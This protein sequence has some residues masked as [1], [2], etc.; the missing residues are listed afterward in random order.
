M[1]KRLFNRTNLN[2]ESLEERVVPTTDFNAI[3]SN[4]GDN[5]GQD[6]GAIYYDFLDGEV[7]EDNDSPSWIDILSYDYGDARGGTSSSDN[8]SNSSD[9]TLTDLVFIQ[10]QEST[11]PILMYEAVGKDSS[12]IQLIQRR[13]HNSQ[14]YLTITINEP[15]IT[16]Y[17][18]SDDSDIE[19]AINFNFSQVTFQY[20][21]ENQLP[22]GAPV[23]FAA[24]NPP[25]GN[26]QGGQGNNQGGQNN[27]NGSP[28]NVS[29]TLPPEVENNLTPDQKQEFQDAVDDYDEAKENLKEA[30]DAAQQAAHKFAQDCDNLDELEQKAKDA[31]DAA[32]QAKK[33][34]EDA[35][36]KVDDLKSDLDKA[37]RKRDIYAKQVNNLATSNIWDRWASRYGVNSHPYRQLQRVFQQQVDLLNQANQKVKDLENQLKEAEADAEE[38]KDKADQKAQEADQAQKEY[39]NAKEH[40]KKCKQMRDNAFAAL[41]QAVKD[42]EKAEQNLAA[43]GAKAAQQAKDNQQ[44][45]LENDLQEK[46]DALDKAQQDLNNKKQQLEKAKEDAAHRAHILDKALQVLDIIGQLSDNVTEE[47]RSLIVQWLGEMSVVAGG[48]VAPPGFGEAIG[49]LQGLYNL[50]AIRQSQLT[51]WHAAYIGDEEMI[52]WLIKKG[53]ANNEKE[54]QEI[55]DAMW[56]LKNNPVQV[57]EEEKNMTQEKIQ[58]CEEEIQRLEQ[59]VERLQQ[60]VDQAQQALNDFQNN[61]RNQ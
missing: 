21:P 51:P 45:Q 37:K 23:N 40:C 32:D 5:S 17:S 46:Q 18:A 10:M 53:H 60:Q 59:E 52:K 16:S 2:L 47:E 38:A 35:Q 13:D 24:A 6:T 54:A 31:Q 50:I 22:Q 20:K 43:A 26:N 36:D 7:K 28:N 58:K 44:Q 61:N 42:F 29:E 1:A 48:A 15:L 33:D 56:K 55:I 27:Q 9:A 39:E 34:A 41:D 19:G 25:L 8:N 3:F 4:G 49:F 12:S 57:V 30:E 11:T 14:E